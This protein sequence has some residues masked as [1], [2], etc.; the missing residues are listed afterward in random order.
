MYI[1]LHRRAK[2]CKT[3]RFQVNST[4]SRIFILR[5]YHRSGS[6]THSTNVI[7]TI[8]DSSKADVIAWLTTQVR[9]KM[10][11]VF[12]QKRKYDILAINVPDK[13]FPTKEWYEGITTLRLTSVT[14]IKVRISIHYSGWVE[15]EN[16]HIVNQEIKRYPCVL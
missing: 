4:I 7:G 5:R 10:R 11:F 9:C 6:E 2:F 3:K 15:F 14:R 1:L 8:D 12:S 13:S 16:D